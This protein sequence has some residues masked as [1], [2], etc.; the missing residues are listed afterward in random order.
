MTN[1]ENFKSLWQYA[2]KFGL[3]YAFAVIVIDLMLFIAGVYRGDY[4]M[5][6]LLVSLLTS[7]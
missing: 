2:L 3:I 7:I 1:E 4:P 6:D 5:I